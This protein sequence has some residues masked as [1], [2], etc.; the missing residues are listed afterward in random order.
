MPSILSASAAFRARRT[1][2]SREV[3]RRLRISSTSPASVPA[4]SVP[5]LR[6]HRNAP[7]YLYPPGEDTLGRG[8]GGAGFD[9]MAHLQQNQFQPRQRRQYVE[10]I[11]VAHVRQANDL[12]LQGVL[13]ASELQPILFLQLLQQL[14]AIDARGDTGDGQP[15]GRPLGEQLES[16]CLHTRPPCLRQ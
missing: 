5:P 4:T 7:R 11:A 2:D 6:S 13:P 16:D 10:L 15:R 12:S 3:P 1:A 14:V 9:R 8:D